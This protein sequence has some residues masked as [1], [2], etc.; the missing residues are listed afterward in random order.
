MVQLQERMR[1]VTHAA[2]CY[3][4][5]GPTGRYYGPGKTEAEAWSRVPHRV[6][7]RA[8]D[9]LHRRGDDAIG[10]ARKRLAS[11]GWRVETANLTWNP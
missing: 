1:E 11:L 3:V 7:N 6:A 2:K 9:W 10:A 4:L 8:Y 5:L